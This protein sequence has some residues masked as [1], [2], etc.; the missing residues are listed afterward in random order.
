M[1]DG[2]TARMKKYGEN[3][4]TQIMMATFLHVISSAGLRKFQID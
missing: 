2:E 3:K 1:E 4:T